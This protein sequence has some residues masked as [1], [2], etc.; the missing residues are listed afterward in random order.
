MMGMTIDD[1]RLPKKNLIPVNEGGAAGL[2]PDI[3][4]MM[5]EYYEARGLDGRGFPK[6]DGLVAVGLADIAERLNP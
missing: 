6:K 2:V 3:E 1:D 4:M 5:K